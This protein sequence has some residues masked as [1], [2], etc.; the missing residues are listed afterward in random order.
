MRHSFQEEESDTT[1]KDGYETNTH[2]TKI[3]REKGQER[4]MSYAAAVID[5]IKRTST[6]DSIVRNRDS[7]LNK[8]EGIVICLP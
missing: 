5:G 6:G 1:R 2:G 3:G 4:R 8:N 7:T